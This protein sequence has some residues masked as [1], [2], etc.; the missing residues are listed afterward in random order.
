MSRDAEWEDMCSGGVFE[1]P[2]ASSVVTELSRDIGQGEHGVRS[3]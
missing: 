3:E 1:R 2:M